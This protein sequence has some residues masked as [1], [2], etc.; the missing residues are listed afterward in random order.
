MDGFQRRT[1]L[2]CIAA[3]GC[4]G[5]GDGDIV[6]SSAI[7]KS[8]AADGG[9]TGGDS[10]V[11]KPVA[12]TE[13]LFVNCGDV[14]TK[15]NGFKGVTGVKAIA[16]DGNASPTA[17]YNLLQTN[18][19]TKSGSQQRRIAQ[20]NLRFSQRIPHRNIAAAYTSNIT[21]QAVAGAGIPQREDAALRNFKA[22]NL[23]T[24][25]KGVRKG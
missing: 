6:Q 23:I 17:E 16:G 8:I 18:T 13:G 1:V 25:L 4:N 11:P 3:Y 19:V 20:V 7:R 10:N 5:T 9:D 15:L 22:N 14:I 21:K 2:E 24:S 12:V